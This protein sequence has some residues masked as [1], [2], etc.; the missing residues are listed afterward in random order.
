MAKEGTN[1]DEIF[2]VLCQRLPTVEFNRLLEWATLSAV[3]TRNSETTCVLRAI[4]AKALRA[5]RGVKE[6]IDEI[7]ISQSVNSILP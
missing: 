5:Q 3:V 1:E 2:K 7:I 6:V 4:A